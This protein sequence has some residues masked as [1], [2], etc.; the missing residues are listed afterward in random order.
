[1][2]RIQFYHYLVQVYYQFCPGQGSDE[3]NRSF[4]TTNGSRNVYGMQWWQQF[5]GSEFQYVF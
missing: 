5:T 4:R 1:M 2:Y 3:Y